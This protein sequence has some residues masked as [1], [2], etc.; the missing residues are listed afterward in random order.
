M[1]TRYLFA[2]KV[3]INGAGDLL[4]AVGAVLSGSTVVRPDT[5]TALL[6][7]P[8]SGAIT[9]GIDMG[10]DPDSSFPAIPAGGMLTLSGSAIP[11]QALKGYAG[12]A[13]TVYVA[14]G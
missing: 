12:S 9:W 7:Q 6:I 10:T 2:A 3:T 5:L 14:W 11:Y 8:I 4:P 1:S 13:T